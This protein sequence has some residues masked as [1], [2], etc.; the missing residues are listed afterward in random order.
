MRFWEKNYESV[1]IVG[2]THDGAGNVFGNAG[3]GHVRFRGSMLRRVSDV[4]W[5]VS[6]GA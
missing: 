6:H 1:T 3:S 4:Q 2:K 5:N